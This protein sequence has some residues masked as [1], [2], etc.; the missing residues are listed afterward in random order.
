LPTSGC[1]ST[2]R[3]PRNSDGR[4]GAL[5][6]IEG[7]EAR[8]G[9]RFNRAELLRQ[10]LT[11][12]SFG[13][14]NNE[15]LEFLGDSVL[16]CVMAEVLLERFPALS[17]GAL[18]QLR[19]SLV[20][21]EALARAGEALGLAEHLRLGQGEGG[22]GRA[23][24]PSILADAL[25]ALYGAVFLDGGYASARQAV[26]ATLRDA[27]E[28]IDARAGAKD[29][30]TR[31]QEALQARR[32]G[33][34]QYAVVATRGAAHEQTFEV[35]CVVEHLGLRAQGR[36]GSRRAAEQQAAAAVLEQ[37]EA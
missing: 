14:P 29:A 16:G 27:L 21:K 31:L 7:L 17:E 36:G 2:S 9:H 28:S 4:I 10:A 33:L 34:P 35:E 22:A 5:S 15:R 26:L 30:K 37:L 12:R 8:L 13:T 32:L 24:A 23:A 3:R 20:R 6:G 11:H 25:E 1:T 18:S 19:A